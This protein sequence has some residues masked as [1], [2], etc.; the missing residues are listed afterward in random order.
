MHEGIGDTNVQWTRY[1]AAANI[2]A[3]SLFSNHTEKLMN[4]VTRILAAGFAMATIAANA[5]YGITVT[6]GQAAAVRIGMT[7][8]AVR[9]VLGRPSNVF[10]YRSAPGSSWTY[11]VVGSGET[12]VFDVDFGSDGRVISARERVILRG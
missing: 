9:Q 7:P 10:S 6:R 3:Q 12:S 11:G 8:D 1:W 4:L 5:A 2:D